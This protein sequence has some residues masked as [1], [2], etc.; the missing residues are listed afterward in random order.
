[1]PD[2]E[3]RKREATILAQFK[4]AATKKEEIDGG[5]SFALA[6]D[7]QNLALVFELL[8]A[9]RDCCPFL[10]FRLEAEPTQGPLH[11]RIT[12]PAGAKEVLKSLF[13]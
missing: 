1:L 6:G 3:L 5:Y 7:R 9:E 10:R 13:G 12:G 2:S 4:G 11:L 8:A